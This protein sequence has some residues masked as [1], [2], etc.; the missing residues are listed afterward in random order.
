[1]SDVIDPPSGVSH[2]QWIEGMEVDEL[3]NLLFKLLIHTQYGPRYMNDN[4]VLLN[5]RIEQLSPRKYVLMIVEHSNMTVDELKSE[6]N[7]A[8]SEVARAYRSDNIGTNCLLSYIGLGVDSQ[9]DS[10][11]GLKLKNAIR[12]NNDGKFI[13]QEDNPTTYPPTPA[14]SNR[15]FLGE[16]GGNPLGPFDHLIEEYMLA[17]S[18]RVRFRPRLKRL[19]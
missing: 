11:M 5:A 12:T 4:N 1:M 17:S 2:P 3:L 10:N 7:N 14:T 15:F 9:Y 16:T 8:K 13:V 19:W 6:C 18:N